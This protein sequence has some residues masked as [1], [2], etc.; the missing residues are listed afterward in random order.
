[1]ARIKR[2]IEKRIILAPRMEMPDFPCFRVDLSNSVGNLIQEFLKTRPNQNWLLLADYA[3][4]SQQQLWT[5]WL[6]SQRAFLQNRALARS[7][8]A[9]FLRYIA[10]THHVSEAFRKVG[11]QDNDKTA[12]VINLPN[13]QKSADELIPDLDAEEN[14]QSIGSLCQKL[15]MS[16]IDGKPE[17]TIDGLKK[18]GI[19]IDEINENTGDILVGLTISTELNS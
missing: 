4:Q 15:S 19:E 12:W 8:D 6:L 5:A 13:H 18:L 11:I 16:I 1:M 10:G 17:L 9:E 2:I 3:A 7:I 14:L